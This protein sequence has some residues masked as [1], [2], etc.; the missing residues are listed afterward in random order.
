MGLHEFHFGVYPRLLWIMVSSKQ[1]EINIS[2]KESESYKDIFIEGFDDSGAVSISVCKMDTMKRGFLI[3]F[4]KKKNIT[5]KN[6]A[7][8][9]AH[10]ASMLW[11]EI[12]ENRIGEEANAY[13]IGYIADCVSIAK[14]TK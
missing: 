12:G 5:Y 7:H 10:V 14:N 9:S 6:T 3:I 8:E 13:L 11:E 4:P 2:F 1:S